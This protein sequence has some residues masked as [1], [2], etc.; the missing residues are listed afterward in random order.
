GAPLHAEGRASERE[1]VKAQLVRA[2]RTLSELLA[3]AGLTV[4]G[5]E[6]DVEHAVDDVV[7]H[8]R[9]DLLARDRD[10]HPFV[11]DL[12]LGRG[13]YEAAL[14]NGHALQ[15]AHYGEVVRRARGLRRPPHVAYF[16]L[17]ASRALA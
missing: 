1:Q 10:G 17:G 5:V 12:K 6:V 2:A 13:P 3:D 7:L 8:G 15:L 9:V 14:K 11:L 4:E 16:A